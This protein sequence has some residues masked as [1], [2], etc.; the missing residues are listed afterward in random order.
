MINNFASENGSAINNNRDGSLTVTDSTVSSNSAADVGVDEAPGRRGRDL[1][2]RGAGRDRDDRRQRLDDGRQPRRRRPPGAAIANDGAG[3]CIVDATT[4]SKN[5]A[6]GD[7]GAISNKSGDVTVTRSTFAENAAHDGGAIHNDGALDGRV[8]VR[9]SEFSLNSAS[10]R[11]GAIEGG[12]T[13]T[14]D[15]VDGA[16]SKNSADDLGG[17][18]S[19]SDKASTSLVQLLV[20]RELGP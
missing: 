10:A 16:F 15:V 13:G 1:Q 11:G 3:T 12:G 9:D 14:V 5:V 8:T 7:G 19:S 4:F 2:Q 17:A 20:H 6:A 18:I